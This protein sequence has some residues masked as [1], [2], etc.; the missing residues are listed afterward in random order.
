MHF[1]HSV[2]ICGKISSG[3]SS[4][5]SVLSDQLKIP[6]ASFGTMVKKKASEMGMNPTRKNLQD[7]GYELFTSMGP[8]QLVEEAV[9][10]SALENAKDIVFDGVR[11]ELVLSEIR[12]M[13]EKIFL[14]YLQADEQ[15]RFSRYKARYGPENLSLENFRKI[16]NHPIEAGTDGLERHADSV[17]NAALSLEEVR[18]SIISNV[19]SFLS[20]K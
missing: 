20:K 11:H 17:V 12:K 3:K 13:S 16:D 1:S 19:R 6:A 14:I 9:R 5:I 18:T 15:T 4:V 8:K 7:L 10:Y 2:L